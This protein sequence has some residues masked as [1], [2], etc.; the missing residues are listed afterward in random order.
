[1][2]TWTRLL[3]YKQQFQPMVYGLSFAGTKSS[4]TTI[5]TTRTYS[6][7]YEKHESDGRLY[8]LK[9][10]QHALGG[11]KLKKPLKSSVTTIAATRTSSA[12]YEKHESGR[13]F[14]KLKISEH[15]LGRPKLKKPLE[16][17][18]TTIVATRTP[19]LS[20]RSTCSIAGSIG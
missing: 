8:K 6:I 18:N 5:A 13:L 10:S 19:L 12:S 11:S 17:R 9:I 2:T 3:I 20:T 7:S 14:Y 16:S 1:M 15:A 4:V